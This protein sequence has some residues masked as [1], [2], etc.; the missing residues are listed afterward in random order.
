[1]APLHH[2]CMYS[3]AQPSPSH[4]PIIHGH[5]DH[6]LFELT[7]YNDRVEMTN[8]GSIEYQTICKSDTD[9]LLLESNDPG[10]NGMIIKHLLLA[11]SS[12][13]DISV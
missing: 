3:A 8:N 5:D 9:A 13:Y 12:D 6:F 11:I 4:A 7:T 2:A 1:M 10:T